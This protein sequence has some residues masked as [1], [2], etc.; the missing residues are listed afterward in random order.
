M[1]D[2]PFR[3]HADPLQPDPELAAIER[4]LERRDAV[5]PPPA[6]R[7]RVLMA[8]QDALTEKKKVPATKSGEPGEL[9][10]ADCPDLVAGTFSCDEDVRIP[11]WA[12]A[13]AAML[14]IALTV[15]VVAGMEALRCRLSPTFAA[16][17]RA[18]G[19]ADEPL[20]AVVD[21]GPRADA[22][23]A[24]VRPAR[25]ATPQRPAFHALELQRLLEE[26]L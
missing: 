25:D 24:P 11:G 19:V 14:G 6:L 21:R 9:R 23:V 12:W 18:A 13:A 20:L 2:D 8:V 4:R 15:P 16:Q 22:G 7:H 1:T 17:L 26:T 10:F 3:D 5:D